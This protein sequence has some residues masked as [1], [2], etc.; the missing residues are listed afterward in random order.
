MSAARKIIRRA[1]TRSTSS[2]PPASAPP[3][4][5]LVADVRLLIEEA[6][7]QTARAFNSA[8]VS[9]YWHIG[10]RILKDV[11]KNWRAEYGQQIVSALGRQLLLEYDPG[12]SE[13]SLRH[14][15]RFAEAFPD[16]QIVSALRRQL[17]WTHSRG[18]KL[19]KARNKK[20]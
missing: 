18:S 1:S 12:F 15:L 4:D 2:P 17:S 5:L 9:L 11:L 16:V 6:R 13:K 7:D 3:I 20:G 8:L 14:M 19:T 10:N